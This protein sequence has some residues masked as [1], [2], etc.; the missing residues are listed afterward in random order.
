MKEQVEKLTHQH[1]ELRALADSYEQALARPEPNL[2]TLAKH[3]WTLARLIS[4]H[5]AVERL[6]FGRIANASDNVNRVMEEQRALAGQLDDHVRNWT[7][8]AIAGDWP[9]YGRTCRAMM[10]VMRAHLDKEER[11]L[12]PL[13]LQAGSA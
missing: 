4:A 12:Y 7:V 10:A 2:T 9:A 11:E 3:R 6:A 8:E 13:L 1:D 5:L